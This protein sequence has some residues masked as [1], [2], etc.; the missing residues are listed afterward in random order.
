MFLVTF[1]PSW[2]SLSRMA[3]SFRVQVSLGLLMAITAAPA[4]GQ[5]PP[6]SPSSHPAPVLTFLPHSD[7][8]WW[9]LSGQA[10]FIGQAHGG[11][12]SPYSGP[13]SFRATPENALSRVLTL[14]TGARLPQGWQV[15]LDVEST[16]GTGL[17]D[18]FGLAGFTN[19]DV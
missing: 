2:R 16:G 1:V 5:D 8:T 11:F 15:I 14:Y 18:A 13:H 12:T 17:S 10:N 6:P 7:S 9:W 3:T 19:L 4:W